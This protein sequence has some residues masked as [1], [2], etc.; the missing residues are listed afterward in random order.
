MSAFAATSFENQAA[1]DWFYGLEEAIDPG[2][3]IEAALDSALAEAD[4]LELELSCEAIAAAELSASCAGRT[5]EHLPDNV[6]RWTQTHPHQ[7]YDLEIDQAV[8][9]V[10]RVRDESELR[11][12]WRQSGSEP[13]RAWLSELDDLVARLRTAGAGSPLTLS[14]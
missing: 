13:E 9:A 12:I 8:D 10:T 4:H 6:R 5:P 3:A 1:A 7:P 14:P 11:D 2:A